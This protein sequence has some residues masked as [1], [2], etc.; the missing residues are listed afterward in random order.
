MP[1]KHME[2]A[3][4]K[5]AAEKPKQH[6]IRMKESLYTP[7]SRRIEDHAAEWEKV[8]I[9][10][11]WQD[12]MHHAAVAIHDGRITPEMIAMAKGAKR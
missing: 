3:M 10:G 4:K 8:G 11:T 2:D 5:T 12:V 9:K 6:P 7:I 1:K